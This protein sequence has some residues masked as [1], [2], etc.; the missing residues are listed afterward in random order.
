MNGLLL[1]WKKTPE[2]ARSAIVFVLSS[3]IIKGISFITT[4]IFTR[5]MD[6]TQYGIIATYNS[7]LLIIEV[8]ALLG[9]TS[10]GLFNVGLNDNKDCCDKY[11]S[12]VL[13]LCNI[14]TVIVFVGLLASYH[15]VGKEFILS[16]NLLLAMFINLIFSP[17]QVFW[18][19][20]Q[21]YEYKYKFAFIITVLSAIISQVVS[22]IFV[23]ISTS[24]NLG[25][26]KIWSTTLVSV[27]FNLPIYVYILVKGKTIINPSLW[28]RVLLVA[29]PLIPHYLAQHVMTG[30]DRIMLSKMSSDSASGIYSVVA[31]IGIIATLIWSSINSS[32]VPYT[33]EKVN[34]GDVKPVS[35]LI[36]FLL[37]F[38]ALVCVMISLVAPEVM[39]I[40]APEEYYGGIYSIP[41]ILCVS[42]LTALYNVYANIEFYY[43]KTSAIST[44]TVVATLVNIVANYLLIP[45][46]AYNGASYATLLSYVVLI[47][48]HYVGYK[49]CTKYAVYNNKIIFIISLACIL[50]CVALSLLYKFILIRYLIFL[51]LCGIIIWKRK[52]IISIINTTKV[53]KE[54]KS[55]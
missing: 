19:T 26:I 17:A 37:F 32:L 7:W 30:A 40:L 18:I 6:S 52:A 3:F 44:A 10:A 15:F 5:L 11:V 20:R 21:K 13:I 49:R 27:A 31:N 23:K 54:N 2:S 16:T 51:V 45:K 47:L 42:F 29:I 48:M 36:S 34:N 14:C 53:K 9:L 55:E 4:P 24:A 25:A 38:Y 1:K 41:P 22:V 43:K 8:F 46:F 28:R 50:G 12:S 39:K 35:K 33:Y